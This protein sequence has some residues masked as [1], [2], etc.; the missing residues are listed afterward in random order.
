MSPDN[1]LLFVTLTL[2]SAGAAVGG[3][4]MYLVVWFYLRKESYKNYRHYRLLGWMKILV[5]TF[6]LS[7]FGLVY[8][9]T[10]SFDRWIEAFLFFVLAFMAWKNLRRASELAPR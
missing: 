5:L 1:F 9:L 7:N 3:L 4:M 6:W 8:Y 10:K 2:L